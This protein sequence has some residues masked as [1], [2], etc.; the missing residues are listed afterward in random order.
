M[1]TD[2][3][4]YIEYDEVGKDF[5]FTFDFAKVKLERNYWM[6]TLLASVCGDK[7]QGVFGRKPKGVPPH[8]SSFLKDEYYFQLVDDNNSL[9]NIGLGYVGR[10]FAEKHGMKAVSEHHCENSDYHSISYMDVEELELVMKDYMTLREKNNVFVHKGQRLKKGD[11]V[12]YTSETGRRTV[13][14]IEKVPIPADYAAV[15]SAMKTLKKNGIESRFV[16]FFDN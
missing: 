9:A 15:I 7:V 8:M 12:L 14:R 5:I 16:F 3:H 11:M 10:N 6:F 2:I 13:S 4:G 1:G